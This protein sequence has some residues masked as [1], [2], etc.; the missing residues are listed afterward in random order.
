MKAPA[1]SATTRG[2]RRKRARPRSRG[3]ESYRRREDF[4]DPVASDPFAH[5]DARLCLRPEEAGSSDGWQVYVVEEQGSRR[6]DRPGC[7]KS[8]HAESVRALWPVD[9]LLAR[10]MASP[11]RQPVHGS[12]WRT[13]LVDEYQHPD[14]FGDDE[15]H[16]F[17]R[18]RSASPASPAP[19]VNVR[20]SRGD[21]F[22]RADGRLTEKSQLSP[23]RSR[24]REAAGASGVA[25]AMTRESILPRVPPAPAAEEQVEARPAQQKPPFALDPFWR[26]PSLKE[27]RAPS[28]PLASRGRSGGGGAEVPFAASAC[29]AATAS[30]AGAPVVS[31]AADAPLFRAEHRRS[32]GLG[33]SPEPAAASSTSLSSSS[34]VEASDWAAR[35]RQQAAAAEA[36]EERL[37]L[38][39]DVAEQRPSVATSPTE[40]AA[41]ASLRSGR[42]P[43]WAAR[44]SREQLAACR[45]PLGQPL[46]VL[47]GPG[48]GKTAVLAARVLH[49]ID[50]GGADPQQVVAV[51]FTRRAARELQLRVRRLRFASR[52]DAGEAGSAE[53]W[54]GTVH[55]LALRLLREAGGSGGGG[56]SQ[57]T[58]VAS[59]EERRDVVRSANFSEHLREVQRAGLLNDQ[60]ALLADESGD[61][62]ADEPAGCGG[63]RSSASAGRQGA[64]NAMVRLLSQMK[65]RPQ[66]W[67][68]TLQTNLVLANA[69]AAFDTLLRQ[70]GLLDVADIL[71]AATSLLDGD[72]VAA[73][74]ARERA[75]Q[76][77]VDEWQDVD[78][79]Q[80]RL[81][82]RL[83]SHGSV[84]AVGDDD[85]Q[86][87]SWMRSRNGDKEPSPA[88]RFRSLWPQASLVTLG[89]N[90]RSAQSIVKAAAQLV[91]H[92]SCR[93]DKNLRAVAGAIE[94][95]V[96]VVVKDDTDSEARW[97]G[98]EIQ[99][100][101]GASDG[102][103]AF[104]TRSWSSF[105]VL[106]RT[107]V[108]VRAIEDRFRALGIPT[109]VP[110]GSNRDPSRGARA[111]DLL[112]YMR[113]VI[114]EDHD[115]SFL[116]IFNSP[117]RG[118]GKVA[119]KLL[120]DRFGAPVSDSKRQGS[121]LEGLSKIDPE[122]V[123]EAVMQASNSPES[124]QK[125]TY[126]A[127][128]Q[129]LLAQPFGIAAKTLRGFSELDKIL[130]AAR[131]VAKS[132]CSAADVCRTLISALN[133]D[134]GKQDQETKGSDTGSLAFQ[135]I[136]AAAAR[137]V[138]SQGLPNGAACVA[139]FLRSGAGSLEGKVSED[140]VCVSTIH[141]AKGLEWDVVFVVRCSE[142][143]MPLPSRCRSEDASE[144]A[145][146]ME[147]EL[148][149]ERRLFY[150]AM[151]RARKELV[152]SCPL[153][154]SEGQATDPSRFLLE[155]GLVGRADG[156]ASP[157]PNI[158][159]INSPTNDGIPASAV[160]PASGSL[161]H[162][163]VLGLAGQGTCG[164]GE[165][166]RSEQP[167]QLGNSVSQ[168]QS[169]SRPSCPYSRGAAMPWPH[170]TLAHHAS[171]RSDQPGWK[172]R[173][174]HVPS[175]SFDWMTNMHADARV[176]QDTHLQHTASAQPSMMHACLHPNQTMQVDSRFGHQKQQEN[177]CQ[178]DVHSQWSSCWLQPPQGIHS[179]H[180]SCTSMPS[181]LVQKPF[182]KLVSI[183][184]AWSGAR[185]NGNLDFSGS[186]PTTTRKALSY[187][188]PAYFAQAPLQPPPPPKPPQLQP[189]PPSMVVHTRSG[190]SAGSIGA[191]S[192]STGSASAG[193]AIGSA[194]GAAAF[195]TDGTRDASAHNPGAPNTWT[196]RAMAAQD[197]LGRELFG[198]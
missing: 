50:V 113:L 134:V 76:I 84:T 123:A 75:A 22:A 125:V 1:E 133:Y 82:Q 139:D 33:D 156:S 109:R 184:P 198:P 94:G 131:D 61:E 178:P 177:A 127:A 55:G 110:E 167:N 58:R 63:G 14:G 54:I 137:F 18:S 31:S 121:A 140:C 146:I 6:A 149:E 43:A 194:A 16:C 30:S 15:R 190:A 176:G 74:W 129:R 169:S 166:V 73:Q 96:R 71:P 107:N 62:P 79:M 85:Q 92:N 77:F 114:D 154:T 28:P 135:R 25:T 8:A 69:L 118:L 2:P 189:P 81:L 20:R 111:Q 141:A 86:I 186:T 192:A 68:A 130:T 104:S 160:C 172:E 83:G 12:T 157:K 182:E 72:G 37:K 108:V 179:G 132:S 60:S 183:P 40:D 88:E 153:R 80:S 101:H 67:Q 26:Q 155:A 39:H 188:R 159:I 95:T 168:Q 173:Q 91:G 48:S 42:A 9:R 103:G 197:A 38:A 87:Y 112:A 70:R 144:Q 171:L 187:E 4:G 47:A 102:A 53:P 119:L 36:E 161:A 98:A 138:P 99:K 65:Q 170:E 19:A 164:V 41:A 51:T 10:P 196:A 11:M 32:R 158:D 181:Q 143:M 24:V 93:E 180:I 78:E 105:A 150:V 56:T 13:Q 57:Y 151:T 147:S 165:G 174:D 115:A 117:K 126:L 120:R 23:P 90:F 106:A 3:V 66:R 44:L 195:G 97:I 64:A 49:A 128:M 142:S 185:L 162:G 191:G 136:L 35:L 148:E 5:A 145:R 21:P 152:V 122:S 27:P 52:G 124:G 100:L 17:R 29:P 59:E 193:G 163:R 175:F 116:R 45:A 7:D 89:E 34:R 46:L